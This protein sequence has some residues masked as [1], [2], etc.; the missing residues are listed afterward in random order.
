[1][2]TQSGPAQRAVTRRKLMESAAGSAAVVAAGLWGARPAHAS[3]PLKIICP[4]T[5]G[6]G[7]DVIARHFGERLSVS[8]RRPVIVDNKT[9]GNGVIAVQALRSQPVESQPKLSQFPR[10]TR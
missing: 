5:S 3:A 1:M 2:F 9:G 6:S 10:F 4:F 7:A 8:L